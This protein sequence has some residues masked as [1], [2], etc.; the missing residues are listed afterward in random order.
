MFS[1]IKAG[2]H[3]MKDIFKGQ[4]EKIYEIIT[5]HGN[6]R[7]YGHLSVSLCY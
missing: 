5:V 2:T 6:H 3:G 1:E 4:Y 7:M